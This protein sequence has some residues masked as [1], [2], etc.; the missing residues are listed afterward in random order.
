MSLKK[1]K[2]N[3]HLKLNSKKVLYTIESKN[4]LFSG[5]RWPQNLYFDLDKDLNII[6]IHILYNKNKKLKNLVAGEYYD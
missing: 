2:K 4:Y 5:A 1:L 3:V 6:G